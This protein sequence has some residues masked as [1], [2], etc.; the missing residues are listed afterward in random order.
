MS[1][2]AARVCRCCPAR[3]GQQPPAIYLPACTL[4]FLC[5]C[6]CVCVSSACVCSGVCKCVSTCSHHPPLPTRTGRFSLDACSSASTTTGLG[7]LLAH[8]CGFH[9]A[10]LCVCRQHGVSR[11]DRPRLAANNRWAFT[12]LQ[13]LGRRA[14][15]LE[16]PTT[17]ASRTCI[18]VSAGWRCCVCRS[19]AQGV[20][21]CGETR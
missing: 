11:H 13:V 9:V 1:V 7:C 5:V 17:P 14:C 19:A 21:V 3:T 2:V 6:M 12:T 16:H 18:C 8:L 10:A 20:S 15:M 4:H